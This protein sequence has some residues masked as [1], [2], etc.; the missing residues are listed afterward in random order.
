MIDVRLKAK[1]TVKRYTE[2]F[3]PLDEVRLQVVGGVAFVAAGDGC[4]PTPE[5]IRTSASPFLVWMR[6][7]AALDVLRVSPPL[8]TSGEHRSSGQRTMPC[9]PGCRASQRGPGPLND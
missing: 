2:V 1:M 9:G 4:T 3:N 7:L 8:W 6:L 5:T